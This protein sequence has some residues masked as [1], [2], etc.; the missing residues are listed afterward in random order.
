M[1]TRSLPN[2]NLAVLRTTAPATIPQVRTDLIC[3]GEYDHVA[4]GSANVEALRLAHATPCTR[5]EARTMLRQLSSLHD[6]PGLRVRSRTVR[7]PVR[8]RIL[9][10]PYRGHGPLCQAA[11]HSDGGTRRLVGTAPCRAGPP[12]VCPYLGR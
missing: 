7:W 4:E 5:D 9:R 8:P 6:I 10:L 1:S 2:T 12:R 3:Q 11:G